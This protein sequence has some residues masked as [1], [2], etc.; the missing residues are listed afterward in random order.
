MGHVSSFK[1]FI[2]PL[3][4]SKDHINKRHRFDKHKLP[5]AKKFIQKKLPYNKL[6]AK[7]PQWNV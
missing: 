3:R 7:D 6:T 4:G 1:N 2:I 5:I